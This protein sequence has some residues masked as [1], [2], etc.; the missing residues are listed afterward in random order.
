M[1][2]KADSNE[3]QSQ[4][5]GRLRLAIVALVVAW[6][7]LYNLL[8]KGQSPVTSF[9]QILDTIS[10]DYVIGTLFTVVV[11][12][13]VVFV[14]SIT[15]LYT[16]IICNIYSF[17][18]IEDLFY[19]QLMRGDVRGFLVNVVH[20]EDQPL[21][22]RVCPTRVASLLF[23]FS[24]IYA[25]SWVYLV[26]F[27][28]A[29]FFVSWS[30]GV[31]LPFT[32]DNLLMLPMLAIAIPFSARVM[33]YMRYPYAQ[34]YADF[35]PGA[36]FVL[37]VVAALGSFFESEDQKFFLMQVY[38]NRESLPDEPESKEVR[39]HVRGRFAGSASGAVELEGE[40]VIDGELAGEITLLD[41]D[42]ALPPSDPDA[43]GG[44]DA[45]VSGGAAGFMGSPDLRTM[46]LK[47][48]VFLA[49][50]PIFF[51]AGFWMFELTREEAR[52]REREAKSDVDD[53]T[54]EGDG[55]L[56]GEPR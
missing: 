4:H 40:I 8:I 32:S 13:G 29:L 10:D 37:L 6:T 27:S 39:A 23:S 17:K 30:A 25:M 38:E 28:E 16:Q 36:V 26:L 9:F 20:F 11:G 7:Y 22:D 55:G 21:P 45:V 43:G 52:Q 19:G 44:D 18:I 41:E 42:D 24:F 51:E 1:M 49:F 2:P 35:M 31:D 46:F 12:L 34:D 48:G 5:L 53:G 54:D 50:I 56:S 33:A 47:N 14:F 15:K 3:T